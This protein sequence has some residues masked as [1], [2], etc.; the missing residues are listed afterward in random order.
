M[1][2]FR[3][4]DSAG[5]CARMYR[6]GMQIKNANVSKT[7]AFVRIFAAILVPFVLVR[8]NLCPIV[9]HQPPGSDYRG[10][11]KI[12]PLLEREPKRELKL[13]WGVLGIS[14]DAAGRDRLYAGG[15]VRVVISLN[16]ES[17][18]GI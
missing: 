11:V 4:V 15:C 14:A 6:F 12:T 2:G 16:V 17:V 1:T 5:A 3:G 18:E 7:E 10:L 8:I 9:Q 13:T